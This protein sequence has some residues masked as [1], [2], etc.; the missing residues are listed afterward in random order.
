[1]IA[2]GGMEMKALAKARIVFWCLFPILFLLAPEIA[3]VIFALIM[4]KQF[5]KWLFSPIKI[6]IQ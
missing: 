4:A 6:K 1:M 3:W 5:L 2:K